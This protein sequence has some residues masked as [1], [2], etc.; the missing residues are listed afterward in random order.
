MIAG[1]NW[2]DRAML[3]QVQGAYYVKGF[4]K[5]GE[6]QNPHAYGYFDH[7]P[8]TGFKGGHVTIG[9]VVYQ[10]GAFPEQLRDQYLAA[11]VLSN[12]IYWHAIERRGS[13]FVNHFGGDLL[14]TD[15][16]SFRPVDCTVGPDGSLFIADWYDKRANH[17][18]PKDDWDRSN[19]R[20]YKLVADGTK[21]VTG[22]D[23]AKL[24]SQQLVELLTH[25]NAWYAREARLLL[26]ERQDSTIWPLLRQQASQRDNAPRALQSLWALYASGG[27]DDT[28]AAELLSHPDE[29]LRAWTVR[30]LGDEKRVA[31]PLAKQLITIARNEPSPVVR[32]QLA[33]TA[34]RLPADQ[35]LPIT[36]ALLAHDEDVD[37]AHIPLLLWWS[38]E[39]KAVSDRE[40][41]LAL[42][43]TSD[44][45]T[46]P[47]T[48]TVILQRLARR[49][50]A[51][52]T[53]Q[54]F[55]ACAQLLAAAPGKTG[56]GHTYGRHGKG[57][58]RPPPGSRSRR[59]GSSRP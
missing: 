20:I 45:W 39:D 22:L 58:R 34:K 5:H 18:D 51:G 25:R 21:A 27:F 29:D 46:H 28:I 49:Y 48:R 26:A 1:T 35:G 33:C 11:N 10:G 36:A 38:V 23:L 37:D 15:D 14:T 41:V 3:H 44:A 16:H 59:T 9:G 31:P 43:A 19:G 2:G 42:F 30:L 13:S 53:A 50:A 32:S 52:G 47:L 54:D 55:A 8:Y 40:R 6:L 57:A 7:V 24:S 12:A 17:V 4:A 56:A